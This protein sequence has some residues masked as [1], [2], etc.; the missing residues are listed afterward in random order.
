VILARA[1][2]N[3][4]YVIG[5]DLNES[6]SGA[7]HGAGDVFVVEADE[8]DGT[9]LL[10]PREVAVI[11]NVE[12]DH[13]TFFSGQEDLEA[14]FAAFAGGARTVVACWDDAGVRGALAAIDPAD[15]PSPRIVRYGS[16]PEAD[17]VVRAADVRR[18]GSTA[19]IDV[20][21]E[22][23]EV[24]LTVLGRHNVSNAAAALAAAAV[25]GIPAGEA[26]SALSSFSGVHRRFEVRGTGRGATFVDDYAHHPTEVAVTVGVARMEEPGRL[27]AVLQP[28][29]YSRTRLLWR[30][31][32]ESVTGADLVVVT[33][34]FAASEQPIPG[35]TG[36]L[37]VD[38]L[39]ESAP[40][41]RIVYLP[42]RSEVAPFLAREAR[43]GDLVVTLG[44]GD[45]GMVIDE[46]L[47]RI[48]ESTG[49]AEAPA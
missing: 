19:R 48:A 28:H 37:V 13:L 36:K 43:P 32:A 35:V 18:G 10:L 44:C 25:L 38:A 46:T 49:A 7:E 5:G 6:G 47:D 22:E 12:E 2:R 40:G 17:V 31:Y 24:R 16:T 1:G 11:T 20:L 27:V 8:S 34:V 9:F 41:K 26:A 29:R 3:P 42:R 30:E 4:S 15:G 21:G 23:V 45:I 14:A 39:A 33:D